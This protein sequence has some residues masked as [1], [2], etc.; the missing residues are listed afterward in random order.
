[1]IKQRAGCF[2]ARQIRRRK[3]LP[4]FFIFCEG[5]FF[6]KKAILKT[7]GM[8]L[9]VGLAL[10]AM[11]FGCR[12]K[13]EPK[14]EKVTITVAGDANVTVNAPASFEVAKGSK[15][16]DIKGNVNVTY[17]EGYEAAGFKL[18]NASGQ[19]LTDGYVFNES[20]TVFAV[21]KKQ[22]VTITVAGDANVKVNAPASFEVA[23]GS[24]WG[25]IK[26]NVNV[27]YK[28][29][30]EAAG[31]K[32]ENAS[33]Q[34]LTDDYAFNESKTVFA[35]SKQIVTITVK[36]DANVTVNAPASFEVAKGSKWGDIK[37]NV[38][39]TYK[40]GYE[41]AGFKLENASG[42]DLTD[43][44]AFNE[45]KTVFAVSKQIVITITV[46]G[47]ERTDISSGAFIKVDYDKTW[48][49]IKSQ[50]QGKVGLKVEWQGGDYAIY[51]WRLDGE[52]GEKLTDDYKVKTDITVYAV[53]NYAKF[54][55]SN[56]KISLTS[57]GRG[58]TGGS[59]K[60]KI[61]IP[62]NITEI[63]DGACSTG[64]CGGAFSGCSDLKSV[65]F[66][67]SLTSI[68]ER[69]F[70]SCSGLASV[71]LS[72]CTS[73]TS[74]GDSAFSYCTRLKNVS[75]P[76]S[77]TWIG[78][79]AFHYC[80][81]LTSVS[82]PASLTSIGNYAFYKC[83]GLTSV[84]LSSYTSLTSIGGGAFSG[85]S[86]LKS[87]TFP[88]SLTSIGGYAFDG[89]SGL[90]SV[91]LSSCTSLT[92]IGGDAFYGCKGLTS[93][94]FPASLTS[95][96]E[97]AFEGC[98]GLK[99]VNFPTSLTSIGDGAFRSC[100]GLTSVT[101]DVGNSTYKA[102]DNVVYT[103]DGTTLVFAAG[104]LTSVTI[105]NTVTSIGNSAFD[106]CTGLTSVSFPA[107]LTSI[108]TL[109]FRGCSSLTSVSLSSCTS[110]TS[111]GGSA[112][113]NCEGL[114]SVSFPASLTSIGG[115]AFDG[116]DNLTSATFADAT[117]WA[118]YHDYKYEKKA[119]DI[120]QSDLAN[121]ATAAKYLR[122]KR[123]N[124]GYCDKYWKKN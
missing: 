117:G 14:S 98:K 123:D 69:A 2:H 41:A 15:W 73:L 76:A 97:N 65:T 62:E 86:G 35:V 118:V 71:D 91:D 116:C 52:T 11:L 49:D 67:A 36:G 82:F 74:I 6:M 112:F 34:D 40:E 120:E 20:K 3:Q 95:I 83:T 10:T 47:D 103:K 21:S 33:G 109:A 58:Y 99:S 19:D 77:L 45:S 29:G 124:G 64:Y 72:S 27:T 22:M 25:D 122:E 13:A 68:G 5:G 78:N 107:S 44:Y 38:N 89:C 81:G 48:Q 85:C 50:A 37:G 28:E 63:E 101:V 26:G 55:I 23:K 18:E 96:G 60:G 114:T 59:P 93:V 88:A 32:L 46:K 53:T 56:N 115:Y 84:D 79:S 80:K 106:G 16:G 8:L 113:Y 17:K 4:A 39:V 12:H 75:F 92:S 43:D 1:M 104:G 42:Q 66:P 111:I 31:F 24:K 100:S 30:Y 70:G 7:S 108:G 54:N 105:P 9:V 87:V 94:S 61:I 51:E 121:A 119:T 90:T 110:L 102:V 57:E